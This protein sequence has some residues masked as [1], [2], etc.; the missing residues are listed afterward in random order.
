VDVG[1]V[2]AIFVTNETE[3]ATDVN[4]NEIRE[5]P[6]VPGLQDRCWVWNCPGCGRETKEETTTPPTVIAADP[7]C[8][9]CRKNPPRPAL[10]QRELLL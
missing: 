5:Q 2:Q 1:A 9:R 8:Y 7:L 3:G 4:V 6:E 10:R